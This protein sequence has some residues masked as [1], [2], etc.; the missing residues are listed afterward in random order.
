MDAAA[1]NSISPTGSFWETIGSYIVREECP[2]R[3]GNLSERRDFYY[4]AITRPIVHSTVM[5]V[6]Q[7]TARADSLRYYQ[8]HPEL[9][10]SALS[11]SFEGEPGVANTL[12][13]RFTVVTRQIV[14][15]EYGLF[16]PVDESRRMYRL[17]RR[18]SH[19]SAN[20]EFIGEFFARAIIDKQPLPVTFSS[21]VYKYFMVLPQSAPIDMKDCESNDPETFAHLT[22]LLTMDPASVEFINA[23]AGLTFRDLVYRGEETPATADNRREYVRAVCEDNLALSHAAEDFFEKFYSGNHFWQAG[24][25]FTV[26]EFQ[27]MLSDGMI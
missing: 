10:K 3:F 11:V 23:T 14:Q 26:P 1:A 24:Y 4:R 9:F 18:Y 21:E 7:A 22:S 25:I 16:E 13:E 20:V 15:A 27:E 6:N 19:Y 2:E 5:I 17:R 12:R 8:V